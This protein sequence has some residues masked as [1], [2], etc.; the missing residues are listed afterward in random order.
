MTNFSLSI[1]WTRTFS[2]LQHRNFRLFFWGQLVS[3]I[4]VWMQATAQQWLVYRVTGSQTSLGL[5]TFINFLPVL[6][7]SLFMGVVADQFSR[8]NLLLF[9][10]SWFMFLAGILALLTWL[11]IVQYWHILALSFLL[12]IGNALDMPARQAFVVEMVD[13]NKSDVMNAIGINSALFNIARIVGPAIGGAV[14]ATLG[15]APA[16]AANGLSYLAVIVALLLMRLSAQ[17]TRV[18]RVNPL[19]RMGAGFRYIFSHKEI[20]GLV[21]M[22]AAISMIGFG[23]LTLVPVFA[24]DILKIGADG[25]GQ[26]LSWQGIGA[27]IG[28]FILLGF[29]DYFHKGKLLLF[30]R[31]LLGPAI[32]GIALSRIPWVSMVVM[33]VLGY[34]L[35]T[36]LVLTNTLIQTIVPD[37][38]RGRVLSTYTWAL[39]GFYPLGSLLMG[40]LGDQMGA[41]SAAVVSGIGSIG[42]IFVNI[43]VFPAMLK[44]TLLQ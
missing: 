39:G 11:D 22:V 29:G 23:S 6:L 13:D 8:R 38:L 17:P 25:F 3:V 14:V 30:S 10:Q 5:V 18:S 20:L 2:A 9:T 34:S 12:G 36:Q 7:F 4:G 35:I 33:A 37:D 28:A 40:F 21:V 27:L 16:F 26:L 32:I 19:E 15:E 43:F 24:K 1:N 42:L 31:M 41:P 44:L